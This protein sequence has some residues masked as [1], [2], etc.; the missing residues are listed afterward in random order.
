M[1]TPMRQRLVCSTEETVKNSKHVVLTY[2]W[3]CQRISVNYTVTNDLA[4]SQHINDITV[5]SHRHAESILRCF[6]TKDTAVFRR[7]YTVYVR[8]ILQYN[9]VVWSPHLKQVCAAEMAVRYAALSV[10]L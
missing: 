3:P 5:K 7:A 10:S 2:E 4:P 6:V 8:P 1:H 9:C